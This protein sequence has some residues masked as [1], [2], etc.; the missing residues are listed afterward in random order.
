MDDKKKIAQLQAVV[1]QM[2][3]PIKGVPLSLVVEAFTGATIF[4]FDLNN[5]KDR[6]LRD[7]LEQAA[8]QVFVDLRNT[9]IRERRANEVGNRIEGYVKNALIA[10]GLKV[11]TPKGKSGKAKSTGYPDLLIVEDADRRTY[12]E[13][14]TFNRDNINTTLRA[15]YLSPSDDFKASV[16]AR[17]LLFAF[18]MIRIENDEAYGLFVAKSAKLLSLEDLTCDVKFEF[19]SDNRRMYSESIEI[20]ELFDQTV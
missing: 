9:P 3:T 15:F 17:H 8:R 19:Q 1:K 13:C 18:E 5:E 12:V 2:L 20:F 10:V 11:Q 16:D 7:L 14:K 4:P 6:A